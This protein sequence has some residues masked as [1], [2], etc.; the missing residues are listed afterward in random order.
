MLQVLASLVVNI[1]AA[2]LLQRF[3][4]W[5]G[6]PCRAC[7]GI[8]KAIAAHERKALAQNN[9]QVIVFRP[10]PPAPKHAGVH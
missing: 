5:W 3:A 10:A 7:R 1:V 9:G 4:P 2:F 6:C 8:R